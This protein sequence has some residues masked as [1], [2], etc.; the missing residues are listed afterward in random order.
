MCS[1]GGV[2]RSIFPASPPSLVFL[3]EVSYFTQDMT[4][5]RAWLSFLPSSLS[6][7]TPPQVHLWKNYSP[8]CLG[9]KEKSETGMG[10]TVFLLA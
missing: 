2:I 3:G 10:V 7:P 1:Q 9:A 4:A 6:H 5:R 8:K